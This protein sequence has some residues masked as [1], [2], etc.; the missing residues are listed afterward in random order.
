M[1]RK[2]SRSK[3]S[4]RGRGKI[5]GASPV[6]FTQFAY[7]GP[8]KLPNH[9]QGLTQKI[10]ETLQ[11]AATTSGGGAIDLVFGNSPASLADWSSLSGLWHEYRVLAMELHYV[12]IKQVASW[13]YG[14]AHVVVD[15]KNS[16]ALGSINA[17]LQHESCEISSMYQEWK[18]VVKAESVE[19]D[20]FVSTSS[21]TATQYIKVYSSDN[22][23]IQTIGRFY[24]TF[25]LELR[26]KS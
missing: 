24:L 8:V 17:A 18:R 20:G 16:T 21:P 14:P 1:N 11:V 15:R 5:N 19:E 25:L 3:V 10:N 7:K 23:T 13:A 22:A 4:R 6:A 9:G 2:S 26:N 12:P